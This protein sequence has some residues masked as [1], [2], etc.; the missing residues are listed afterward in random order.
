[1]TSP[2]LISFARTMRKE[3]TWAEKLMWRWLRGR[4]FSSFKFR[5][6]HPMG[7][8]VLDFYCCAAR[9]NI[10]LDG[11]HHGLPDQLGTTECGIIGWWIKAFMFSASL[12]FFCVQ[13]VRAFRTPIWQALQERSSQLKIIAAA[14]LRVPPHPDPLPQRGREGKGIALLTCL[15][16]PCIA[17]LLPLHSKTRPTFPLAGEGR[18]GYLSR[19]L[20]G[21]WLWFHAG[22]IPAGDFEFC[23]GGIR[24]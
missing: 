13:N 11:N 15:I 16:D 12:I 2:K 19:A 10:E 1:M 3:D 17:A 21:V 24:P 20:W 18:E 23:E 22:L 6:Q 8:Y 4:R 9:V 7:H 5:R 14:A